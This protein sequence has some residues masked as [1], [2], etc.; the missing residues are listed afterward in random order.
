MSVE[1]PWGLRD[2]SRLASELVFGAPVT[3]RGI[4]ALFAGSQGD[5][6]R[7]Y[8]LA[9][10]LVRDLDDEY[11]A[12]APARILRGVANGQPFDVAL[13]GVTERSIAVFEADF[14]DRQRT[15]TTW[16]P[17]VA[18]SSFLWLGVIGLAALAVRRR[19]RRAAAIRR[20]WAEEEAAEAAAAAAAAAEP[21]SDDINPRDGG[22]RVH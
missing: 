17:L 9:A 6:S 18:S 19:R 11:G 10:A 13:A 3:L 2:R 7:A 16:I 15:W 14:W 22:W 1:R 8:S 21:A 12:T 20:R 5:Q 4:D